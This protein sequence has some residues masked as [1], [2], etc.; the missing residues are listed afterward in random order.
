M[1]KCNIIIIVVYY[2]WNLFG[3]GKPYGFL[4]KQTT[5]KNK[6]SLALCYVRYEV[7]SQEFAS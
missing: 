4:Q 5:S 1:Q 3:F 2:L 6:L 7:K